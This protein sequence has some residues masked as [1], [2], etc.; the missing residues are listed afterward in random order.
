MSAAAVTNSGALPSAPVSPLPGAPEPSGVQALGV[1]SFALSA[2]FLI[3]SFQ[4][5]IITPFPLSLKIFLSV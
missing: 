5:T 2:I 1:A 4:I 3:P